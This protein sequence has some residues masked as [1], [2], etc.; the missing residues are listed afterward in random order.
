MDITIMLNGKFLLRFMEFRCILVEDKLLTIII[1]MQQTYQ[2]SNSFNF[3][4][5][6]NK[7]SCFLRN[8]FKSHQLS[9]ISFKFLSETS[10]T[11]GQ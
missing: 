11:I 6:L 1:E 8:V 7:I 9:K 2:L 5:S 4:L 3:I 10:T